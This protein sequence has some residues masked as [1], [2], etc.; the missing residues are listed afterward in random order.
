MDRAG[1]WMGD[2]KLGVA[3]G[4]GFAATTLGNINAANRLNKTHQAPY[5]SA[6]PILENPN[7]N[8]PIFNNQ[9][10]DIK[11]GNRNL[12]NQITSN[13][14][15]SATAM[16]R[17]NAV[18]AGE[19]NQVGQVNSRMVADRN[20]INNRNAQTSNRTN[21]INNQGIN[22][23]NANQYQ[24]Q[25]SRINTSNAL[26]GS[27]VG[28]LNNIITNVRKGEYQDAQLYAIAKS[29]KLN[30]SGAITKEKVADA[31]EANFNS[32]MGTLVNQGINQSN[33]SS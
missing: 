14:S 33:K 11:Q 5:Q 13:T 18:R 20:N 16:A 24:D 27:T 23:Y 28:S 26:T 6:R 4:L 31:I 32:Q 8:R 7:A 22:N 30:I 10:N 17:L 15:N 3:Q 19:V 21:L 29:Y 2:N 1:Q 9:I 12:G 25:V